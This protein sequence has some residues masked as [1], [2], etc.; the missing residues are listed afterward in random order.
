M[1]NCKYCEN[2]SE[3]VVA[4]C[5]KLLCKAH[6]M[7]YLNEGSAS[8]FKNLESPITK[9]ISAEICK[10]LH[11]RIEQLNK[12]SSQLVSSISKLCTEMVTEGN[13]VAL[14]LTKQ[15]LSYSELIKKALSRR[16]SIQDAKRLYNTEIIFLKTDPIEK[17]V[18][19]ND[20]FSQSF[21]K[22]SQKIIKGPSK[23]NNLGQNY[24][25]KSNSDSNIKGL[26]PEKINILYDEKLSP[27]RFDAQASPSS[28]DTLSSDPLT[29]KTQILSDNP[30]K[31]KNQNFISIKSSY[32]QNM[33]NQKKSLV[34]C[35]RCQA[36][37]DGYICPVCKKERKVQ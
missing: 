37:F 2:D 29:P 16:M 6:L 1:F 11:A 30:N 18:K 9:E 28:L 34:R 15:A 25:N 19:L 4:D 13:K 17:F 27:N 7:Q 23:E 36:M 26:I 31:D 8:S 22:V 3:W 32:S 5:E 10:N 24:S 20:F 14:L 33:S 12:N 21:F 35:L